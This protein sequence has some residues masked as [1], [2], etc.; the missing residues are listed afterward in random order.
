[1]KMTDKQISDRDAAILYLSTLGESVTEA[2]IAEII[3]NRNKQRNALLSTNPKK[4]GIN[5]H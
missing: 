3:R 2:N 4:S 5:Y 1:M